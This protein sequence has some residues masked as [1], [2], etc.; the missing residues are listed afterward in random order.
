M[1]LI[2]PSHSVSHLIYSIYQNMYTGWLIGRI[3]DWLEMGSK[4]RACVVLVCNLGVLML[5]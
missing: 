5:F 3:G 1:R 2:F 4:E